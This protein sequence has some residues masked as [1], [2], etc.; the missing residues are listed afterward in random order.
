LVQALRGEPLFAPMHATAIGLTLWAL[1][2]ALAVGL[3]MGF[4]RGDAR[5]GDRSGVRA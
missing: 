2:T 3:T 4:G 5:L 1:A